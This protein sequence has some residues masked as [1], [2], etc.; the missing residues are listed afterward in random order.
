L[1]YRKILEEVWYQ[2]ED[3]PIEAIL[4]QEEPVEEETLQ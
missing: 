4:V 1:D 3:S 2:E